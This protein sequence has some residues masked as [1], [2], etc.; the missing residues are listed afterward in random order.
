MDERQEP[1]IIE[2]I[3]EKGKTVHF[4]L[5][6]PLEYGGK[7]YLVLQPM[8]EEYDE[9][10]ESCIIMRLEQEGEEISYIGVEDEQEMED[11]YNLYLHLCDED[12]DD[13]EDVD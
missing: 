1:D 4:E 7:N 10:D 11:V 2:L 6:M 8:D 9:E 12:E 13:E 5:L 3:D